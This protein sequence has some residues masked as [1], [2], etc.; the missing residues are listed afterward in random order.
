VKPLVFDGVRVGVAGR[1]LV[2]PL[3]F[4]VEPGEV[5][6][7]TG[8]S[9]SGKSSLL[10]FAAGLLLPPLHAEGAVRL[11]DEP[12]A[13]LP[14]EAR[15][16]GLMFQDDLLFPHWSVRQNLLFAL[17]RGGTRH[18]RHVRCEA[19]LAAAELDG[20]AERRPHELSG[21]QRSRV[22]LVRTLLAAPRALLLDEPFGKLDTGL[23]GRVRRIVWQQVQASK[24]PALLVT[25]DLDDVPPGARR[26][27]LVAA[28][29]SA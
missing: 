22:S 6:A 13:G 26:I 3:S 21:G 29:G 4:F 2:G 12:L 8:P 20:L 14:V 18:E 5:V 11:G 28:S 15:R 19:A 24:L 16:L 10:A 1:P 25:H 9:G 7:L 27:E 17:P 23:R